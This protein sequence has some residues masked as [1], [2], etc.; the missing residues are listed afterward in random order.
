MTKYVAR[1]KH[2]TLWKPSSNYGWKINMFMNT[3]FF[4]SQLD[5]HFSFLSFTFRPIPLS[6]AHA[7]SKTAPQMSHPWSCLDLSRYLN[8]PRA[9]EAL[10]DNVS[11]SLV[12]SHM[13][14]S[15]PSLGVS[16]TGFPSINLSQWIKGK[17]NNNCTMK[18]PACF[19]TLLLAVFQ[20]LSIRRVAKSTWTTP[21]RHPQYHPKPTLMANCYSCYKM[22]RT[23]GSSRPLDCWS[24][25]WN[26]QLLSVQAAV[27]CHAMPTGKKTA[28]KKVYYE[29]S[30]YSWR[31]GR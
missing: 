4:S 27:K 6:C 1:K 11:L 7:V 25:V 3:C 12:L 30:A 16:S 13:L 28:S 9:V 21:H 10:R 26:E 29:L 14:Q 5:C 23:A 24:L 15:H 18:V 17:K 22:R 31:I 20:T 2:R 19:S 8:A